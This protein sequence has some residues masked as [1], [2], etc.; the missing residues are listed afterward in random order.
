MRISR[1]AT[2]GSTAR[3]PPTALDD[4]VARLARRIAR[5]PAAALR[6]EKERVKAVAL[7][8]VEDFR[9]DSDLFLSR[10]SGPKRGRAFAP[11]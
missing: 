7:A 1:N 8:P 2:A 5:F 6:A 3:C 4:F 10:P 11:R 9:R